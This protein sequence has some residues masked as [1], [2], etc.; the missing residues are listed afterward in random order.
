MSNPV[1]KCQCRNCVHLDYA[2]EIFNSSLGRNWL[3]LWRML[4]FQI[5]EEPPS[6][7]GHHRDPLPHSRGQAWK[8]GSG[9][10]RRGLSVQKACQ[11]LQTGETQMKAPELKELCSVCA[12]FKSQ[13]GRWPTISH[14]NPFLSVILWLKYSMWEFFQWQL[15]SLFRGQIWMLHSYEWGVGLPNNNLQRFNGYPPQPHPSEAP[16]ASGGLP[17]FPAHCQEHEP[18][19]PAPLP[20]RLLLFAL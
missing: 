8:D 14:L 4:Y 18:S 20:C 17:T 12:L 9:N 11:A 3:C 16:G 10:E 19:E 5:L 13:S 7:P 1:P 2:R 15:W 6:N